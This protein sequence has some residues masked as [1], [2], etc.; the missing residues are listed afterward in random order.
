MK[1]L[2]TKKMS[3][4]VGQ[5]VAAQPTEMQAVEFGIQMN[6]DNHTCRD[7]AQH[8]DGDDVPARGTQQSRRLL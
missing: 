8:L 4:P 2:M 1:P 5:P 7:A 3:T 6:E